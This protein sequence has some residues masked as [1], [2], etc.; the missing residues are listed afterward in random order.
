MLSYSGASS[1]H[2]ILRRLKTFGIYVND[3][4]IIFNEKLEE[5][6]LNL[7]LSLG[8]NEVGGIYIDSENPNR[9]LT[10]PTSKQSYLH[11]GF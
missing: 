11:M 3:A 7:G 1:H 5:H 8:R 9:L 2:L 4:T 6:L 10:S